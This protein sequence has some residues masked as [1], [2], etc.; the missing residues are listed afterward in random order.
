M[1]IPKYRKQMISEPRTYYILI[2]HHTHMHILFYTFMIQT[3][4]IPSWSLQ[5]IMNKYL[6]PAFRFPCPAQPHPV[7]LLLFHFTTVMTLPTSLSPLLENFLLCAVFIII[8]LWL[9]VASMVVVRAFCHSFSL[10][11]WHRLRAHTQ[12]IAHEQWIVFSKCQL[13]TIFWILNE[14]K[15]GFFFFDWNMYFICEGTIW[16]KKWF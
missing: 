2:R 9:F 5:R 11:V 14:C 7:L 8:I 4:S 10:M 13:S 16:K 12:H 3:I 1:H 15:M 6:G